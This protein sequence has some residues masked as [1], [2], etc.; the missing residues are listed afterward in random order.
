MFLT[1]FEGNC[2]LSCQLSHKK[3]T[4]GDLMKYKTHSLTALFVSDGSKFHGN[5][6]CLFI[7]FLNC[8]ATHAPF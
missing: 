4:K 5:S 3:E 2:F 8:N 7:P 1:I 6:L